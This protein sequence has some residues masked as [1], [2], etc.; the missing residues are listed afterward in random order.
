MEELSER[1]VSIVRDALRAFH[2]YGRDID[3]KCFTWKS[4]REAIAT[5]TG[6][7]IGDNLRYGAER[8]RVFVDG[9]WDSKVPSGRRFPRPKEAT[10]KAIVA[11]LTHEDFNFLTEYELKEFRASYSVPL[12][13]TE[14]LRKDCDFTTFSEFLVVAGKYISGRPEKD[15]WTIRVLILKKA[16]ENGISQVIETHIHYKTEKPEEALKWYNEGDLEK[17]I[18]HIQHDGWAITTPE[19]SLIFF[20]KRESNGRNHRY[21]GLEEIFLLNEK[22]RWVFKDIAEPNINEGMFLLL[23]DYGHD[24]SIAT[25]EDHIMFELKKDLFAFQKIPETPAK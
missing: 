2:C 11:F 1:Q 15:G 17:A 12:R 9:V 14:F 18:S 10:L 24:L 19:D 6:V 13:L 16:S 21:T 20:L 22:K 3:D 4:M 23:H 8:L 5:Y 7:E 25:D